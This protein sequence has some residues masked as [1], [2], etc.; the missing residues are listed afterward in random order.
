[1]GAGF[2]DSHCTCQNSVWKSGSVREDIEL[3]HST[4][5]RTSRPPGQFSRK[6]CHVRC[7]SKHT[8]PLG[9]EKPDLRRRIW[10][11]CWQPPLH[12]L[13][14]V[15][16]SEVNKSGFPASLRNNL[17]NTCRVLSPALRC[18]PSFQLTVLVSAHRTWFKSPSSRALAVSIPDWNRGSTWVCVWPGWGW[19]G[20]E[21]A[22]E[23]VSIPLFICKAEIQR[24]LT[25]RGWEEDMRAACGGCSS[26]W[27]QTI[28]ETW[29]R[30]LQFSLRE[31]LEIHRS[32]CWPLALVWKAPL[33][34][35]SWFWSTA[36]LWP[37]SSKTKR[38]TTARRW[39][40]SVSVL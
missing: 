36:W 3:L 31:S 27:Y 15:L 28:T 9:I 34:C 22:G 40:D 1:M 7:A 16:F 32:G 8:Q 24:L 20:V 12:P 11:E 26:A 19:V 2:S 25:W 29:W 33:F 18:T 30:V 17:P 14:W 21:D 23:D 38:G 13:I 37:C 6:G 5:A 4:S 10:V 35:S 39:Y